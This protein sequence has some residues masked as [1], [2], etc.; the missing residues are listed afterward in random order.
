[1]YSLTIVTCCLFV[2]FFNTCSS[3]FAT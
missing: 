3:H 1:M 2:W